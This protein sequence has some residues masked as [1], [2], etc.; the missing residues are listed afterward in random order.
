[1]FELSPVST[2]VMFECMDV[3]A[4]QFQVLAPFG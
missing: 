4:Q 1:M 2:N 3:A